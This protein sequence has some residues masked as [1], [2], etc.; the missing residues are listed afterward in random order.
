M[1]PILRKKL[2][3][4]PTAE[5]LWSS[6]LDHIVFKPSD[7]VRRLE[8][9]PRGERL[10]MVLWDD[11]GVH[12]TSSTFKTDIEQY[13]AVDS[14]WAAIR[15]KVAIVIVT[16]PIIG[17]LAKNVKDN[18]TFEV[19]LGRN[20]REQ[21]RRLFYL[22]GTRYVDSNLFKPVLGKPK[23]FDL[24]LVPKWVW[25]RYWEMRL[26]LT[27]E[28]L[29]N[30]KGATDMDNEE[31]YTKVWEIAKE[32]TVSANTLQQ[33]GSR[34]LIPTQVVNG[35]LCIPNHFIPELKKEYSKEKAPYIHT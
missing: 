11:I 20:Q 19:F 34:R 8:E 16:I 21:V 29:A 1:L 25:D 15:T 10:P 12:Y 9:V 7:F 6:V 31:E 5:E 23:P 18:L 22:P 35:E 26:D 13:S 32:L 4:D 14:T 17:R 2:D 27:E 3:R 30:L 24:Y 33:M 28:A